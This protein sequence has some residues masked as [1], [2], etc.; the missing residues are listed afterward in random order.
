[1]NIEIK[2]GYYPNE[3][4]LWED[5]FM[6]NVQHGTSKWFMRSGEVNWIDNYFQGE[7][8]GEVIFFDYGHK[9]IK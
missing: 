7:K 8:E 3:N 2:R 5:C 4:L 9:I 1:M 6:N